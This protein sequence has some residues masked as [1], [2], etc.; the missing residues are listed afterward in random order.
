M[1]TLADVA[2]LAGVGIMS[3]SRV[4][5]GTRKVSP[6]TEEKVR[7]AIRRIGYEPN[8]AARILKGQRSKVIGLIVPDLADP[9][10]ATCANA[11]QESAREAGYMTLMVASSHQANVERQQA[12]MMTQR[13]ISGLIIIAT[14]RQ[15]D[16]L[17][18]AQD[19]G[20]AIVAL[21]RPL[22]NVDADVVMV[23]NR[24]ASIA[25]VEHLVEHGHENILCVSKEEDILAT[26]ERVEGYKQ[27]IRRAKLRPRI[28]IIG[29]TSGT[30]SEQLPGLMASDPRPTAIFVTSDLST[31][32][33]LRELQRTKVKVP[34]QMAL[35]AFDDFDAATLLTPQM[36][37]IRQP[38]VELGREAVSLLLK[39]IEGTRRSAG[40][41]V[42][43]KTELVVRES[44]GCGAAK[45][46]R[47][48]A[49][50]A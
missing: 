36:T 45:A 50:A 10:F 31:M 49:N 18:K 4:V 1:P 20:L 27:A 19:E 46:K 22:A 3:V 33:V 48:Q 29:P 14:G 2:K 7:A 21:D 12:E 5:N 23:D 39:R 30:I 15:N 41:Q 34:Q 38:V 42:I 28:C 32:H 24:D 8:E 26:Q 43:L 44:C 11:I 47:K 37:V 17:I 13:Q 9:F 40:E 35:I 6:E 25:A 16:Y